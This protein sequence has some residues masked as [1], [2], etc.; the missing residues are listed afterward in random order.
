MDEYLK[1]RARH[2]T[3]E[4]PWQPQLLIIGKCNET[5]ENFSNCRFRLLHF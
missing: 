2:S 1:E 5:Q 3:E 4:H